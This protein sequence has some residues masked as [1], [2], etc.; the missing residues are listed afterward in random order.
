MKMLASKSL[1]AWDS[2]KNVLHIIHLQLN[3]FSLQ[4]LNI[5]DDKD[6][7]LMLTVNL[8]AQ[9]IRKILRTINME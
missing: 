3:C 8:S 6:F 7:S 5:V 2:C 1:L 4:N 9:T